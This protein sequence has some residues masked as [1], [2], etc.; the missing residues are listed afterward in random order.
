MALIR[1]N[2]EAQ[3]ALVE[4]WLVDAIGALQHE[5]MAARMIRRDVRADPQEPFNTINVNK[6][7]TLTVRTKAEGTPIT[8]DGPTNTKIP[9]VLNRHR[10]VAWEAESSAMAMG[11]PQAIEYMTDAMKALAEQI[12]T[13]VLSV[14]GDLSVAIGSGGTDL[15]EAAVLEAKLRLS[16]TRCPRMGRVAFVRDE[17][18]NALLS[19][20]KF[21]AADSRGD[22]GDALREGRV[23]RLHGFDFYASQLVAETAGPPVEQHNLFGH[24]D[25]IMMAMRPMPLAPSGSGVVSAYIVDEATGLALRYT[26][27]YDQRYM[28]VVHVLDALYGI[29]VVDDRLMIEVTT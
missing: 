18:E 24:P 21:T 3:D 5:I 25:A 12:E 6:R 2:T 22:G 26:Y 9:I 27:G 15:D 10:Y 4:L 11:N 8:T 28:S 20:D 1:A 29:K 23:G 19:L 7:G 17:Q 16:Q 14:Y 13:D